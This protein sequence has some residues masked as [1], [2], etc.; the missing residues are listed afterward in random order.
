MGMVN[1][2]ELIQKFVLDQIG[3]KAG[4]T[5]TK[6]KIRERFKDECKL[7]RW[8]VPSKRDIGARLPQVMKEVFRADESKRAEDFAGHLVQGYRGVDWRTD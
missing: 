3:K 1:R 2:S 5:H 7:R 6:K 8:N 4:E